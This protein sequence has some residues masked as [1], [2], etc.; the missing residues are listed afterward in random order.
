MMTISVPRKFHH[1]EVRTAYEES[2]EVSPFGEP[3]RAELL[4]SPAEPSRSMR[5]F[6]IN[7][8]HLS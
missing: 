6:I 8:D 3:S 7:K 1:L 2:I 4:E 5:H